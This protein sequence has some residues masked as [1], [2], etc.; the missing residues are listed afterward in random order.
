MRLCTSRNTALEL[1]KVK[2]SNLS[3]IGNQFGTSPYPTPITPSKCIRPRPSRPPTLPSFPRIIGGVTLIM[4]LQSHHRPCCRRY[5]EAAVAVNMSLT[6]FPPEELHGSLES[7]DSSNSTLVRKNMTGSV[8][9]A[10]IEGREDV[11]IEIGERIGEMGRGGRGAT[12]GK[13]S[14]PR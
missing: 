2:D 5:L 7:G 10:T 14:T 11:E 3:N 6:L 12:G 9:Q 13:S 4:R 8:K 1:D